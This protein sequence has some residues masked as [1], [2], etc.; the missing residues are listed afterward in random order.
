MAEV[1]TCRVRQSQIPLAAP[2]LAGLPTTV[3]RNWV[4]ATS[5]HELEISIF[6]RCKVCMG[7]VYHFGFGFQSKCAWVAQVTDGLRPSISPFIRGQI[8]F[9][10]LNKCLAAGMA[11]H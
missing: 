5:M 4:D 1:L 8:E 3:R 7:T 10:I 11:R 2:L 6:Y 9:E